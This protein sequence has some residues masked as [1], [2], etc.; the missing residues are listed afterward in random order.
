MWPFSFILYRPRI[1]RF[2]ATIVFFRFPDENDESRFHCSFI[3]FKIS[4][5]Y[6]EVNLILGL[7]TS[8]I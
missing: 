4:Y 7:L 6:L 2:P 3:G 5:K 8:V 1:Y